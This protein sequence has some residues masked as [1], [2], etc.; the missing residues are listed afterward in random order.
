MKTSS[1]ASVLTIVLVASSYA[2]MAE[3]TTIKDGATIH[4]GVKATTGGTAET[5]THVDSYNN[6]SE[7]PQQEG[8]RRADDSKATREVK[9]NLEQASDKMRDTADDIKAVFVDEDKTAKK[10]VAISMHTTAEGMIG[11]PILNPKG[12]K[13]AKL[14]DIIINADGKATHVVVSDGGLMGIDDKLA[15]FDYDK[16]V[17]QQAD[18]KIVMALSQDM[19]DKAADFSYDK[20]DAAKAKVIPAGSYSLNDVLDGELLDSAGKKAASIDNVLIDNG[21]ADRVI[22]KFNKKLGMGGDVAAVSFAGLTKN[23]KSGEVDLQMSARQSAQFA[24]LEK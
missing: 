1:L 5:Q 21:R 6:A 23:E 16:V 3:T 18:G 11:E 24:Q 8:K 4:T 14:K 7:L 15:A 13:I 9:E 17:T 2:A 22:V 12:E 19:I 20:D 10:P